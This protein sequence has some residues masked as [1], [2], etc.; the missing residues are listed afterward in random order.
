MDAGLVVGRWRRRPTVDL[1]SESERESGQHGRG[2]IAT[3][4]LRDWEGTS[5]SGEGLR[6]WGFGGIGFQN[7]KKK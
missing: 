4:R 2:Y 3:E 1:K 7:S 5:T 6:V